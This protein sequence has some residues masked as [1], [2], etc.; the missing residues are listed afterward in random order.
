MTGGRALVEQFYN[1]FNSGE[2]DKAM[3]LFAPDVVTVEPL[4]GRTEDR[5]LWT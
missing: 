5:D 3:D 1:Q 2:L 4:L